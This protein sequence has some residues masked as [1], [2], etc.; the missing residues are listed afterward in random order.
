MG[1]YRVCVCFQRR[2]KAGE[3]EAP[4]EVKELFA[5]Y[6]EGGAHMTPDQL[7]RFLA[8]V[9]GEEHVDPQKVVEEVLQKRHHITKFARHNLNLDDFHHF[10]FSPELN[11]PITSQVIII[12]SLSLLFAL[13]SCLPLFGKSSFGWIG[14]RY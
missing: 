11:P 4:R 5:K 9:Q 14:S 10:L 13:F 1:S 7:R 8:E 12:H 3:A 6:S 2:F